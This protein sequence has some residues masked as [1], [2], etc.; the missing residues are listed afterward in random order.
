[1]DDARQSSGRSRLD[2]EV[3]VD[4]PEIG[5]AREDV[6]VVARQKYD[7]AGF[8]WSGRVSLDIQQ[9]LSGGDVVITDHLSRP[10]HEGDAVL[11]SDS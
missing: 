9:Q 7:L 5:S 6:F 10:R 11:R 3:R 8:D 4:R 1:M 2:Q